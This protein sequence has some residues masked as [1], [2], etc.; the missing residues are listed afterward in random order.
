MQLRF[1]LSEKL[2]NNA[3]NNVQVKWEFCTSLEYNNYK[4]YQKMSEHTDIGS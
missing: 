1:F 4:Q 3:F 2:L